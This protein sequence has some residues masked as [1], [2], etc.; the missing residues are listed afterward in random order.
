M[1]KKIQEGGTLTIRDWREQI[2][3]IMSMGPMS[4]IAGMI[5]GMGQMK[6]QVENANLDEKMFKRQRAIISSING[7]RSECTKRNR[8][9]TCRAVVRMMPRTCHDGAREFTRA[10]RRCR[11]PVVAGAAG[12]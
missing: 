10:G 8:R 12:P 5:P 2:T 11:G 1:M 7:T 6:K 4:K 9:D 3:S